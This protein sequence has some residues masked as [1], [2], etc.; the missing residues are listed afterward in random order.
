VS[1]IA[2]NVRIEWR[3]LQ[4]DK[5]PP[6]GSSGFDLGEHPIISRAYCNWMLSVFKQRNKVSEGRSIVPYSVKAACSLV[7]DGGL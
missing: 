4:I 6:C 2:A 5:C 7:P 1:S 3:A